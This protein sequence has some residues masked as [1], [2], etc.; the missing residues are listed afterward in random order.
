MRMIFNEKWTTEEWKMWNEEWP[1]THCGIA[2]IISMLLISVVCNE[3]IKFINI[4]WWSF[5]SILLFFFVCA[6]I[7]QFWF[8]VQIAPSPM[9][10]SECWHLSIFAPNENKYIFCWNLFSICLLPLDEICH[11]Y[12]YCYMICRSFFPQIKFICWVRIE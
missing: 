8:I 11:E 9:I 10:Q 5:I 12:L 4:K 3:L 1:I 2:S 7:L 6:D